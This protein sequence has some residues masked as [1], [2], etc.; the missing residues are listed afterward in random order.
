MNLTRSGYPGIQQYG[1]SLWA[2]DTSARWDVLKGDIAKGISL[3]LSGVPFWTIDIGAF[4]VGGTACWRKWC[5]DP[6]AKPVW[7]WNGNYDEGVNDLA[8]CELYV[9]WLQLGTFLP[10]FRSHGTDTPRE[11]WNFGNP[12]EPFYDAINQMILLRYSLMPYIYSMAMR[13]YLEDYTMMR[14]LLFDFSADEKACL[15][16][17]QFLFGDSLL[18]CPITQPMYYGRSGEPLAKK[19]RVCYLPK[20]C[21]WYDYWTGE[22]YFG[23]QSVTVKARLDRI[24]LFVKAGSILLMQQPTMYAGQVPDAL[25]LK[26]YCGADGSSVYYHDDGETYAYENGEYEEIRFSW[27]D[28]MQELTIREVKKFRKEPIRM[29]IRMEYFETMI[30]YDG[31]EKVI[32]L[33]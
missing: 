7:F 30:Q 29:I 21:H 13:V 20:G 11:I 18:V 27:D 33:S 15:A 22:R 17:D 8:Y 32:S 24:P 28:K 23:G 31:G 12:G 2:G 5:G 26:I 19:E 25:E 6:E 4:F 3:C 1:V 14:G 16:D 10:L 9:R